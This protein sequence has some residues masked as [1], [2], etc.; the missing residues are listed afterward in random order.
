MSDNHIEAKLDWRKDIFG[1]LKQG[2]VNLSLPDKVKIA[3]F[4]DKFIDDYVEARGWAPRG[5]VGDLFIF[6]GYIAPYGFTIPKIEEYI[7]EGINNMK[8]FAKSRKLNIT[9]KRPIYQNV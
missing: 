6:Y 3:H 9:L 8:E 4:I 2:K 1:K 5:G 7:D